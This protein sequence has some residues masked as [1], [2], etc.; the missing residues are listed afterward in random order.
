MQIGNLAIANPVFLAPM[1]GVSDLPFRRVVKAHGAGLVFSEMVASQEMVRQ[2]R[3]SR[4]RARLGADEAP[5]AVQ[6]AGIDPGVMA[7]AAR[8]NEQLGAAIIDINFGCPAK[9]VTRKA[10]GAAIMRD[11][12]LAA[13]IMRAVVGAVTVPVTV[14]MRTGWDDASRNAVGLARIAE[15]CG[16]AMITVHGRTRC[17]LYA[18]TADWNFISAVKAAVAVPVIANGDIRSCADAAACLAASG[19]DGV[20]IGRGA[21]GRP[22]FP[23]DVAHYLAT[24]VERPAPLRAHQWATITRHYEAMLGHYGIV[25]GL[26][27]ARKHLGWYAT[28]LPGAAA[29]REAVNKAADPAIVLRELRRLGDGAAPALAA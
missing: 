10:A 6:L 20:M 8:L 22:W 24:G 13:A 7:E 3:V 18:G 2:T 15:N 25:A 11:E 1:S 21:Q 12:T 9:K 23:G 4:R 27:V 17:Q 14:K 26:R 28:G 16:I 19:A 29:F 5:A